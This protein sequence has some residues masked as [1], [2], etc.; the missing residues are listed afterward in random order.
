MKSLW[1]FTVA[2]ISVWISVAVRKLA[3]KDFSLCF[4]NTRKGSVSWGSG[5]V[6]PLSHF[7]LVTLGTVICLELL[8]LS[9]IWQNFAITS[10]MIKSLG[11]HHSQHTEFMGP[12][13]NQRNPIFYFTWNCS[14][15]TW[16]FLQ[17]SV[18]VWCLL[19]CC[20]SVSLYV[21]QMP[22]PSFWDGMH[23]CSA[24]YCF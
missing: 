22:L 14:L 19:R 24:I 16:F 9:S 18:I 1:F 3:V 21:M 17:C 5:S 15:L 2:F 4:V 10:R 13:L 8:T 7:I 6:L 12:L 11:F 23:S 20:T